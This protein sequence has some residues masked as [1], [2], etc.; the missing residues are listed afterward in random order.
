MMMCSTMPMVTISCLMSCSRSRAAAGRRSIQGGRRSPGLPLPNEL[1]RGGSSQGPSQGP[2]QV[3]SK[4]FGL[5]AAPESCQHPTNGHTAIL[6]RQWL[7]CWLCASIHGCAIPHAPSAHPP[8]ITTTAPIMEPDVE[9]VVAGMISD[10]DSARK[11]AVYHLQSLLADPSFA[12]AFIQ[13][14]G[15]PVLRRVV[16]Q[17][18]G[19]TL[20]YALGSL[21][22]LLEVEL[23]WETVGTDI[24]GRVR[25]LGYVCL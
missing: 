13:G 17:E 3:I 4:V 2:F 6:C 19:N 1:K 20:A 8:D 9:T 23:G 14:N 24:I 21:T 18:N 15:L 5:P 16:M 11:L 25:H 7:S 22:R 10:Q 12:D